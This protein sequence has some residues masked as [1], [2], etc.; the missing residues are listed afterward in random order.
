MIPRG[1]RRLQ[2]ASGL[3][4]LGDMQPK[5]VLDFI[6]LMTA[7]EQD[8]LKGEIDWLEA[9]EAASKDSLPRS[10]TSA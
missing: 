4:Q 9:Y 8:A 7:E 1:Q 6:S 2:L 3:L 5:D 10:A